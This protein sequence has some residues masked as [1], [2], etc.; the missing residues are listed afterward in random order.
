MKTVS[1]RLILEEKRL[2]Y[3]YFSSK[4]CPCKNPP[5][6]HRCADAYP[7][8]SVTTQDQFLSKRQRYQPI[9]LPQHFSD[10]EMVRDWTLSPSDIA[11]VAKYRHSFRLFIAIQLCA[12]RL[13]GRFLNHVHELSPHIISYLGQQLA[14]PPALVVAVPERKATYTEHRHH[15]MTYLGF[16]PFDDQA[17]AQLEAWIEHEARRGM[18]P[19]ALFQQVEQHLLD[20]RVLLPGPSVLERLIIHVCSHVHVQLFETV[21]SRLSPALRQAIDQLLLVPDGEQHSAFS[22][23]K[24]YPPAAS[25]ASIQ[26]YLQRYHTVAETGIDALEIPI[27]TP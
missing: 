16:Q 17:H 14:L 2:E 10:E 20:Q 6:L 11:E 12:V 18:L 25:I 23:L 3:Q 7:E 8:V 9:A 4:N 24:E 19:D 22:R 1:L 21:F 27:L 13:Y 5:F 26:A 15:I